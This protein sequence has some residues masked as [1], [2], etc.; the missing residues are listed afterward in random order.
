[1]CV[2]I[3]IHESDYASVLFQFHFIAGTNT[4][5]FRCVHR[6]RLHKYLNLESDAQAGRLIDGKEA[7]ANRL[8]PGVTSSRAIFPER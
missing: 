3:R 5:A 7:F 2:C 4:R 1:M 8:L 6:D